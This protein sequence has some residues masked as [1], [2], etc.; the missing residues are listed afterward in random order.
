LLDILAVR[1]VNAKSFILSVAA[2]I[3]AAGCTSP[4]GG[5]AIYYTIASGVN[6]VLPKQSLPVEGSDGTSIE[7]ALRVRSV[8]KDR[9]EL[10]ETH[11]VYD[12]FWISQRPPLTLEELPSV[13]R[14]STMTTRDRRYDVVT[15]TMRDGKTHKIY[16]DVTDNKDH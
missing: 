7:T 14:R 1:R 6:A 12:R 2:A 5:P 15:L 10:V 3:L 16:F 4:H 8:P 11:M 9:L 13:A